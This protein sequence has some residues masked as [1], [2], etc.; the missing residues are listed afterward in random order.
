MINICKY[1]SELDQNDVIDS[2]PGSGC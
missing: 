2:L 1:V